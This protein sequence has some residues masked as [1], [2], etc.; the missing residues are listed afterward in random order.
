MTLGLAGVAAPAASFS[1]R[2][3]GS[4]RTLSIQSGRS[5]V[6]RPNR[7][8]PATSPTVADSASATSRGSTRAAPP[9]GIDTGGPD[10]DE[11]R[12]GSELGDQLRGRDA[13]RVVQNDHIGLVGA[14]QRRKRGRVRGHA[15]DVEPVVGQHVAKRPPAWIPLADDHAHTVLSMP[16]PAPTSR[17]AGTA[18]SV[19]VRC[20]RSY[21]PSG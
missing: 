20:P 11:L 12:S 1:R 15:D 9:I 17:E 18:Q 2:V 21:R 19:P 5:I 13:D 14:E 4:L 10:D 8:A 7:S 16:A 3:A 6:P